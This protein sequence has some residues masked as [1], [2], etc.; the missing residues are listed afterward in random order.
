MPTDEGNQDGHFFFNYPERKRY[1][2]A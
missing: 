2:A 1:S